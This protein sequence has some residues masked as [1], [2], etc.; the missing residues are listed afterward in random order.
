MFNKKLVF[1]INNL[2][3]YNTTYNFIMLYIAI[4][5]KLKLVA[6]IIIYL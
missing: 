4:T 3:I 5:Q 6:K 1:I 2:S